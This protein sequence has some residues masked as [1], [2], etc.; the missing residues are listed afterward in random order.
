MKIADAALAPSSACGSRRGVRVAALTLLLAAC[1]GTPPAPDWQSNARS[2]VDG[3]VAAALAGDP[4][5]E[6]QELERARAEISRTGRADLMA[7]AELMRCAARVAS[8]QLEPCEGFEK[9]RADAA[10]AERAYADHLAARVLP[11]DDIERLPPAQRAIATAIAGGDATLAGV[12]GIEDPLSRIIAVAV[13]FEAGKA[14]PPMIVLAVDTAS[15][16]GWRRPLL[17]WLKVQALR[18]EQ[19]G[20]SAEAQRLRRRIELVLNGK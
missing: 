5:A 2:A 12:Q 13:L 14:S 10:P 17:A 19:A 18:A 9:L 1:A 6:A 4:R 16:Q 15:A 11:R 3:A 20:D 7:R 8:L